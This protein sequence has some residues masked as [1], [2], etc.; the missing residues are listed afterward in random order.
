MNRPDDDIDAPQDIDLQEGD[1][2]DF[3]SCP[4]C[5]EP[6][7]ESLGHCQHCD[8]WVSGDSTAAD[9]SRG[10]FWPVMVAILIGIILV[11]WSR[12]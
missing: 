11:L 8:A 9:R 2:L 4:R 6:I 5:G 1:D 3:E 7:P 10:W 12:L